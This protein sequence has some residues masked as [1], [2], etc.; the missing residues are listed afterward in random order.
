[1]KVSLTQ[2]GDLLMPTNEKLHDESEKQPAMIEVRE[3]LEGLSPEQLEEERD[4]LL[5][6]MSDREAMI[7]SINDVLAGYGVE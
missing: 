6:E 1:M 4:R 2:E 7:H 3:V 5:E